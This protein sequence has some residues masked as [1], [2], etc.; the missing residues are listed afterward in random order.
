MKV[1]IAISNLY[2]YDFFHTYFYAIQITGMLWI[3]RPIMSNLITHTILNHWFDSNCLKTVLFW[4]FFGKY[5]QSIVIC[6]MNLRVFHLTFFQNRFPTT[7]P[8]Q[9]NCS[10]YSAWVRIRLRP[11]IFISYFSFFWIFLSTTNLF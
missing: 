10:R 7:M 11:T 1:I 6:K 4:V 5:F 9:K 2:C 8:L 3:S